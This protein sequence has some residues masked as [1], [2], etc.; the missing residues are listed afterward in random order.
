MTIGEIA[1][2]LMELSEANDAIKESQSVID[3]PP[4][5]EQIREKEVRS[6]KQHRGRA[7]KV[8]ER[9]RSIEV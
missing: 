9:I 1:D 6:A 5:W 7:R 2:L 4:Y 8:V 3:N